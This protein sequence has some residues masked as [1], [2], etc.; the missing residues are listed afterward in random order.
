MSGELAI[1]AARTSSMLVA[2]DHAAMCRE[3]LDGRMLAALSIHDED[4][5]ETDVGL[6]ELPQFKNTTPPTSDAD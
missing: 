6:T 5:R 3:R 1:A 2:D 4:R